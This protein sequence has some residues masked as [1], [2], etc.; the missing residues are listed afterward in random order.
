[1]PR[2]VMPH[3]NLFNFLAIRASKRD[4]KVAFYEELLRIKICIAGSVLTFGALI[5][6][7]AQ[8]AN[9]N[10]LCRHRTRSRPFPNWASGAAFSTRPRWMLVVLSLLSTAARPKNPTNWPKRWFAPAC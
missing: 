5:I 6:R 9:N 3:E 2:P 4:D 10:R 1:M 8:S 7:D